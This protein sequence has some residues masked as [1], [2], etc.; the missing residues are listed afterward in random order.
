MIATTELLTTTL[1]PSHSAWV[2]NIRLA[3][4]TGFSLLS[5]G[6]TDF[7]AR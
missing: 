4:G 5:L 6:L 3:P 7:V 2:P 1:Q